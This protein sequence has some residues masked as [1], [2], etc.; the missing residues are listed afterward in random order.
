MLFRSQSLHPDAQA[1]IML[2]LEDF[3]YEE[4]GEILSV[5]TG[6]VRS[7]LFRARNLLK[8]KLLAYAEAQGFKNKR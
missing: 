8:E 3:S 1:V 7:R 5:P 4:M 6:T 2:D